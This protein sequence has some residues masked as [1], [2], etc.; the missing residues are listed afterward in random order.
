MFNLNHHTF[1]PESQEPGAH[2][3]GSQATRAQ[4]QEKP[5]V[6][7]SLCSSDAGLGL[8]PRPPEA[9][10]R[11]S[12]RSHLNALG[13]KAHG[14]SWGCCTKAV[15]ISILKESTVWES[16]PPSPYFQK[17]LSSSQVSVCTPV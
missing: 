4:A 13:G 9:Q 2:Y 1:P 10:G 7:R 5:G 11:R 15:G 12:A 3:D 6:W 16:D 8:L 17:S 14:D